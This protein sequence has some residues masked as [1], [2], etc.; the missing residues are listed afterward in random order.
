M[1]S[2]DCKYCTTRYLCY[3]WRNDTV[4]VTTGKIFPRLV[5]TFVESQ[6]IHVETMLDLGSSVKT[7][8]DIRRFVRTAERT[9]RRDATSRNADRH[10]SR[11]TV[12][13]ENV[14]AVYDIGP[15]RL[16]KLLSAVNPPR[17]LRFLYDRQA[18]CSFD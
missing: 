12:K 16:R 7:S 10:G 11:I 8:R 18:R 9:Q 6:Q 17:F 1:H 13:R 3:C 2:I 14:T 15:H 4:R 5:A